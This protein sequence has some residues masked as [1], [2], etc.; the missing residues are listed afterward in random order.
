MKAHERRTRS[1]R[2][3]AGRMIGATIPF[4]LVVCACTPDVP[5]ASAPAVED[6]APVVHSASS[7]EDRTVSVVN[8]RRIYFGHQSVGS[9][10][11]AGVEALRRDDRGIKVN[12]VQTRDFSAVAGPALVHFLVGRNEDPDSKNADFLAALDARPAPDHGVAMLKYCYVDVNGSIDPAAM[13]A[14]YERTMAEVRSR[15]PDL[16][17][18][19]VTMPLTTVESA[20]RATVKG[21]LG[22]QTA[23]ELARKRQ[24]FN[25]LLRAKYAGK[26][27]I[28]DLAEAESTLP[29]GS[30][31]F[32][33]VGTDT[34]YTMVPQYTT[35][36][37][38]LNDAGRRRAA[39]RFL[40]LVNQLADR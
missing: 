33:T 16:T 22:R 4:A 14:G 9:D 31:S 38:H 11:V 25:D 26:E 6:A 8:P 17:I 1:A 40:G 30:R 12:V 21:L 3:A 35:D 36:G 13:F 10:I 23:R 20:S 39:E 18:V 5:A 34:V 7:T 28:F 19:H 15:H 37:G 27:P 24:A 2:F 32:F 29:D